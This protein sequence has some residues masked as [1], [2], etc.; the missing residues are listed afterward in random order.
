MQAGDRGRHERERIERAE[1]V[2][3]EARLHQLGRAHRAAGLGRRLE[4]GDAPAAVGEHVGGDE[5]V[6]SRADHDCVGHRFLSA[7]GARG[8]HR[9]R[10][11]PACTWIVDARVALD[12]ERR[13]LDAEPLGEHRLQLARALLRVV[14]AER[15]GEHHV[16][17]E[18]RSLRTERPHVQMVHRLDA[19]LATERVAHRRDVDIG[20]H[21]LEQH[22]R[23]VA[24][25]LPRADDHEHATIDE[26]RDRVEPLGAEQRARRRR[27][28]SPPSEPSAS[29]AR[30][31]NAAAQVEV[32]VRGAGERD[33]AH[34]V[35]DQTERRRRRARRAA[36][37]SCGLPNRRIASTTTTTAPA[38]SSSAVGLRDEHL[39]PL[40]PEG[41]ALGRRPLRD[42]RARPTPARARARRRSGARRRRAARGCRTGT[43]RRARPRGTP[44]SRRARSAGTGDGLSEGGVDAGNSTVAGRYGCLGPE[45]L[46]AGGLAPEQLLDVA[47][48]LLLGRRPAVG[49]HRLVDLARI[50]RAAARSTPGRPRTQS[51]S[52]SIP[53]CGDEVGRLPRE[54]AVDERGRG[55]P[56]RAVVRRVELGERGLPAVF[57]VEHQRRE[58]RR[59]GCR[60][61]ASPRRS[62]ACPG[63]RRTRRR[64]SSRC[65]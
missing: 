16:R 53:F 10:R 35:D 9:R 47:A 17:R 14:Q 60:T 19:R 11:R 41:V 15:T 50:D 24:E 55:A 63:S 1:Q 56:E 45:P 26:R 6:R 57:F 34:D 27:R 4:H 59:A 13:V 65:G 33:R 29:S 23:R 7:R 46:G 22:P 12:L 36:S 42:A 58:I 8:M 3:D 51:C 64:R 49:R 52:A 32:A 18:R 2:V 21:R 61:G 43:R 38:K 39:G 37:R 25:Q 31:Q 44:R 28:R 62:R 20:R 30:C 5:T 40:E 48:H 54:H